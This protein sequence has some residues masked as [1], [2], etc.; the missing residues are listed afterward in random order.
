MTLHTPS[1][2]TFSERIPPIPEEGDIQGVLNDHIE[3]QE[4]R[5]SN[6]LLAKILKVGDYLRNS[7]LRN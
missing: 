2:E 4:E 6:A 1:D 5:Q 7:T 3:A